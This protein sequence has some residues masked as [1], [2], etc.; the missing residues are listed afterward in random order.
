MNRP[1]LRVAPSTLAAVTALVLG[2]WLLLRLT[3]VLVLVFLATLVAAALQPA[4]SGIRRRTRLGQAPAA[5]LAFIGSL[6]LVLA[7]GAALI[8]GILSQAEAFAGAL[9]SLA[10]TWR[11]HSADVLRWGSRFGLPTGQMDL[12]G[13][14]A[15][16]AAGAIRSGVGVAGTVLGAVANVGIV[17]IT[18]LFILIDAPMLERGLLACF[19][20]RLRPVVRG[21]IEPIAT[22]LGA[23]VR[24]MLLTLAA[25]AALLAAGYSLIGLPFG[26]VLGVL[27]GLL[28]IVP[29]GGA[30]GGVLAFL[31]A[32]TAGPAMALKTLAIFV[33]A[34]AVQQN[35]IGPWLY[36]RAVD[37]PPSL[38]ILGILLG[39]GLLGLQGALIAVPLTAVLLEVGRNLWVPL[40]EGRP[41]PVLDPQDAPHGEHGQTLGN[42]GSK[43]HAPTGGVGQEPA[44]VLR[45]HQPHQTGDA[46]RQ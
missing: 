39:S 37:L 36:A 3:D 5:M 4:V 20:P 7:T 25:L 32:S 19:P 10:E 42:Q 46:D 40:V 16:R 29:F 44:E 22:R 2:T 34:Q 8:P 12:A 18:A 31:V 13:W 28:E 17:L 11:G 45:S 6:L 24:A 15:E 33:A 14:M 38:L 21:Q 35:L 43:G 26:V 9:P 30:V 23:Y 41:L 27:T 1:T